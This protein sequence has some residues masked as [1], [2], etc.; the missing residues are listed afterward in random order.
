MD[1]LGRA[2]IP[3]DTNVPSPLLVTTRGTGALSCATHLLISY[4]DISSYFFNFLSLSLKVFLYQISCFL[5]LVRSPSRDFYAY[6][7]SP[8]EFG[9][10]RVHRSEKNVYRKLLNHYFAL[11]IISDRISTHSSSAMFLKFS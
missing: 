1:T 9:E 8:S 7:S 6:P 3:F 10:I 11:E 5:F 2:A 4:S